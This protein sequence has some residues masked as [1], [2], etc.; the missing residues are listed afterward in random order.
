MLCRVLRTGTLLVAKEPQNHD[1]H[2][3]RKGRTSFKCAALSL[4][5]LRDVCRQAKTH[6]TA[7]AVLCRR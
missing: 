6:I 5:A 1:L 7:L 2:S 4:A 3:V